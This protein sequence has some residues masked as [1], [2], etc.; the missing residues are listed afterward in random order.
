VPVEKKP[1]QKVAK[2]ATKKIAVKKKAKKKSS[3]K[4]NSP[5]AQGVNDSLTGKI[6][7]VAYFLYLKREAAGVFGTA[8]GDWL[9]AE[10]LLN[11]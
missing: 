9:E 7:E 5:K 4:I 2:K 3:S 6:G 8:E 10:N 1:A 11:Q